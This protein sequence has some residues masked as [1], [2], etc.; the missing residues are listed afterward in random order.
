MSVSEILSQGGNVF[1][2]GMTIVFAILVFLIL[3]VELMAK[4]FSRRGKVT[5]KV[6]EETT[7]HSET[8]PIAAEMDSS[9]AELDQ[10]ELVAVITAAIMACMES[11]ARVP[12]IRIRSIRRTGTT[13]PSW[14]QAGRSE[15]LATRM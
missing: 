8:S 4:V 3:V 5:T 15:Y 10:T 1:A 9:T 6:E 13:N 2:V 12:E 11:S 14:N 7:H